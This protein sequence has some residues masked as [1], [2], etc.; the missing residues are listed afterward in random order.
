MNHPWSSINSFQDQ[1]YIISEKESKQVV[2][3]YRDTLRAS[4]DNLEAAKYT[5][6]KVYGKAYKH[7]HYSIQVNTSTVLNKIDANVKETLISNEFSLDN[8]LWLIM[9]IDRLQ[10]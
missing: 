8:K 6:G 2:A 7:R 10:Q 3:L 1:N 5:L 4:A 9:T